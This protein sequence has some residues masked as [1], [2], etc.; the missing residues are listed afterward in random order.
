MSNRRTAIML[1]PDGI[2]RGIADGTLTSIVS[3]RCLV[4]MGMPVFIAAR[5]S[6]VAGMYISLGRRELVNGGEYRISKESGHPVEE[7]L[8]SC[9]RG[10]VYAYTIADRVVLDEP[11]PIS[12]F[13]VSAPRPFTYSEVSL[14]EVLS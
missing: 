1:A 2:V 10:S 7:L 12:R 11:V 4:K 13:G 8:G 9:R 14:E 6:A 3:K 5:G